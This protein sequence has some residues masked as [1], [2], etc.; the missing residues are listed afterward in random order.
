MGRQLRRARGAEWNANCV[1]LGCARGHP[2][3]VLR[4]WLGLPSSR[5]C[6]DRTRRRI[7]LYMHCAGLCPWSCTLHAWRAAGGGRRAAGGRHQTRP[8]QLSIY[9]PIRPLPPHAPGRPH[10]TSVAPIATGRVVAFCPPTRGWR[11]RKPQLTRTPSRDH[12]AHAYTN[13]PPTNHFIEPHR[14]DGEHLVPLVVERLESP[15]DSPVRSVPVEI[16]LLR[17]RPHLE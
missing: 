2:W 11:P 14:S 16:P 1:R 15:S 8:S 3:R 5:T 6:W 9:C 17:R 10:N 4:T 13:E 12:N 7:P